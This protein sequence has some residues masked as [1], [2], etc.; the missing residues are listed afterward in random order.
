ML[1]AMFVASLAGVQAASITPTEISY[2]DAR[3][4]SAAL[5]AIQPGLT[6]SNV[7]F[8]AQD[9]NVL[10]S[11][12]ESYDSAAV[13]A[14][15]D[16][17]KAKKTKDV[18]EA[19]DTVQADWDNYRHSKVPGGVLLQPITLSDDEIKEAKVTPALLAPLLRFLT[20]KK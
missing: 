10:A 17:E 4:L 16:S 1:V 2:Q 13:K 12:S 5:K 14:A 20:P 3:E 18:A 6:A 9:I 8:A 7:G 19:S 15:R 11:A